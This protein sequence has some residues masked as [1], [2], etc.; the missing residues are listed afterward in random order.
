MTNIFTKGKW[1][2]LYSGVNGNLKSI[3]YQIG[4]TS[5]FAKF[6][7]VAVVDGEPRVI[8]VTGTSFPNIG[9]FIPYFKSYAELDPGRIKK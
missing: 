7:D 9:F 1:K 8:E 5:V 4:E 3:E 6:E 2:P